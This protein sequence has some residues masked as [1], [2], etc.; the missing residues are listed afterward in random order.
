MLVDGRKI[1]QEIKDQL[2]EAILKLEKKPR[3]D[4]V[5]VGEN[6]VI[7]SFIRIKRK[8]GEEIGVE[9]L[10]HRFPET[11]SQD[12]L[13]GEILNIGKDAEGNGIVV[14]L[15]LPQ[16]LDTDAVLNMIPPEKDVDVLSRAAFQKFSNGGNIF[17]PVAGAVKEILG[18]A[19]VILKKD[20]KVVV[21][22]R[23]R[24][25]GEP[26]VAWLS[27][28]GVSPV[29]AD[30]ETENISEL[31]RDADIIISGIGVPGFIK[32]EMLKD[33]VILVDAGTSEQAG[34]VA[35]DAD[36][37]CEEKCS[38][39]TP[40]PGGVGPITVAIL[41]RNLVYLPPH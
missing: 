15:P 30:K 37:L 7:E 3:L 14:Q 22:G 32:P 18:M 36:P 16:S 12:E 9:T 33:S 23:G 39:F 21:L 28:E 41:F 4:I 1:A 10:V 26:V 20:L 35:G 24:L 29:V 38:I 40:V 31:L 6:P 13:E 8:V 25:V 19:G 5:Y 11:I 2:R 27:R 34:K 17:P